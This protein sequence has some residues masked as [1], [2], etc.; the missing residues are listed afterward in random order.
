MNFF[1][2]L[3]PHTVN[4]HAKNQ[5]PPGFLLH[6]SR[7]PCGILLN[8][9]MGIFKSLELFNFIFMGISTKLDK[10][11]HQKSAIFARIGFYDVK[12]QNLRPIFAAVRKNIFGNVV[13]LDLR[14]VSRESLLRISLS[15]SRMKCIC[16]CL[17]L[18]TPQVLYGVRVEMVEKMFLLEEL[19]NVIYFILEN[20]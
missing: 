17:V 7:T 1:I 19:Q 16:I 8:F 18:H 12:H 4:S 10:Y 2:T 14:S 15:I 9:C 3:I 11:M 20:E 6:S 13:T 5:I